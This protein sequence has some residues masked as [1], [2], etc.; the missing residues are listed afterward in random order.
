MKLGRVHYLTLLTLALVEVN[1]GIQA[2]T[3]KSQYYAVSLITPILKQSL[4]LDENQ[5]SF[6]TSIFFI[7]VGGGALIAGIQ[8]NKYGRKKALLFGTLMQLI[9][10][11]LLAYHSSY[12]WLC[13]CRLLYGFGFGST[14]AVAP[15]IITE[16]MPINIRGRSLLVLSFINSIG[17]LGGV[18][19]AF[20]FIEG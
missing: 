2:I 9:S 12:T 13:V 10:A 20:I 5:V 16:L 7:G 19:L 4:N 17:K 11:L 6:L 14:L 18:G 15:V 1:D 3:S 8:S